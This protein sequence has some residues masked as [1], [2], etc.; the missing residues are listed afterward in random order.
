MEP[1]NEATSPTWSPKH[2][3]EAQERSNESNLVVKTP[4]WSPRTKQSGL[5][6]Y[7][8]VKRKV[9]IMIRVTMF[10]TKKTI[11]GGHDDDPNQYYYKL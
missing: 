1:K 9:I 7:N 4:E 3:N 6:P 5:S 10:S 2:R 8:C 11:N